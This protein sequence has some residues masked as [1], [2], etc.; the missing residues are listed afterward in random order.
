MRP[1][2][3]RPVGLERPQ[4]AYIA[5]KLSEGNGGRGLYLRHQLSRPLVTRRNGREEFSMER[6]HAQPGGKSESCP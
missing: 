5:T 6:F 4:R 3:P 2:D 1:V